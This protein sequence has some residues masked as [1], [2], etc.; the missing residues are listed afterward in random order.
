VFTG[1]VF[2]S[3]VVGSGAVHA[4]PSGN[5]TA[6]ATPSKSVNVG[7][8]VGGTIGGIAGVAVVGLLALLFR[9][10]K[11]RE[12][13]RKH[14]AQMLSSFN[15]DGGYSYQSAHDGL[16][17]PP[18]AHA[19][20][21]QGP[22]A[23]G[24][25]YGPAIKLGSDGDLPMLASEEQKYFSPVQYS[26]DSMSPATTN[27][28]VSPI[29][30][31]QTPQGFGAFPQYPPP[32]AHQQQ[33]HHYSQ[34]SPFTPQSAYPQQQNTYQHYAELAG[35]NSQY[36]GHQQLNLARDSNAESTPAAAAPLSAAEA[37]ARKPEKSAVYSSKGSLPPQY[38]P[39]ASAPLEMVEIEAQRHPLYN[40]SANHVNSVTGNEP[41]N[42]I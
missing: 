39:S 34:Q 31:L 18:S 41:E 4:T 3:I 17:P 10:T 37:E 40:R 42:R 24:G 15:T 9:S 35:R 29:T 38:A 36:Y 14:Q 19:N 23:V 13:D 30:A 11:K 21:Y 33:Q 5:S 8:V 26:Y 32:I 22:A 16:R 7:A 28:F 27:Q 25:V 6:D 12:D 20:Q 1:T 2:G